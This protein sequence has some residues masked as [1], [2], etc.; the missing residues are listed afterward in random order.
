MSANREPRELRLRR[1]DRC[2]I[3]RI[4]IP[5]GT[6]ATW[7][8]AQR[9]VTCLTCAVNAAARL[10]AATSG[11]SARREYERRHAER[12]DHARRKLGTLG[13]LLTRFVDEPQKTRAWKTGAE[14]EERAAKRLAKLLA[15]TQVKLLHDLRMPSHGAANIDHI[16]IGPGGITVIDT[17]N[18][19]GKV[20]TERVGGLFS[21]RRTLLKVAGRDRTHLIDG[22]EKQIDVVRAIVDHVSPASID[23]RGTLCFVNPD[24]LP[25]FGSQS[26][27]GIR[28]DGSRAVAK[29]ARRP[30][31]LSDDEI[32][33]LYCALNAALPPA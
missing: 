31:S 22:I 9:R 5:Q 14:G 17:K 15:D 30:G 32:A 23:I 18:Y 29:L 13:V 10:P 7:H 4:K 16:A 21:E 25:I 3:C 26:V 12:E 2:A 24:G 11:I 28:I 19:R 1:A 33:R 8:P 27:R 20:T 6:L